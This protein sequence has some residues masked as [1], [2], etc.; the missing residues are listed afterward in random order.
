M[1]D[2]Q[3]G[4]HYFSFNGE[5]AGL[6]A[7]QHNPPNVS[8][9]VGFVNIMLGTELTFERTE[10]AD[11]PRAS[12]LFE[13]IKGSIRNDF[14]AIYGMLGGD[15]FDRFDPNKGS[16]HH[17]LVVAT[18]VALAAEHP[19]AEHYQ[20]DMTFFETPAGGAVVSVSCIS[21]GLGLNGNYRDNQV[22]RVMKNLVDRFISE[23][24]FAFPPAN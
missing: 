4:N 19:M 18:A 11:S 13:G 17:G 9:G 3:P 14:G 15:E 1:W 6:W 21:W 23:E 2:E 24:P 16:P 10:A 8:V 22:S 5:L 7:N 20:A 12:F